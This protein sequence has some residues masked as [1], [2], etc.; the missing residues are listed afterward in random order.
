MCVLSCILGIF[1][2]VF[3]GTTSCLSHICSLDV[4]VVA[5][6]SDSHWLA[7]GFGWPGLVDGSYI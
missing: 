6:M 1:P 3:R 4:D 7:T 2:L 5:S